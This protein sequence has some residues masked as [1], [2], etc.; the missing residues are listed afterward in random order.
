MANLFSGPGRGSMGSIGEQDD[1]QR[2]VDRRTLIKRV[3]A[4][5][6]VAWTAPLIIDSLT[7]P[8]AALTCGGCFRVQIAAQSIVLT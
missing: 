7:S 4:T 3:A 2:G 5:G 8:A 6:A 1:E